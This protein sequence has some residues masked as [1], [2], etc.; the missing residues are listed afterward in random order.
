M[1]KTIVMSINRHHWISEAAYYKAKARKVESGKELDDWLEAEIDYSV[2]L[3]ALYISVLEEDGGITTLNLRELATFMGIQNPDGITSA[4]ELVQIIQ[5]ATRHRPCFR[6][7]SNGVCKDA[8]DCQ[9]KRECRKL[10]SVMF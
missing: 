9:W 6:S 7:K 10:T 8:A 1:L 3:V 4:V 2:M 5:K